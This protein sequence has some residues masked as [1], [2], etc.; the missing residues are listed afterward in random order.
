MTPPVAT[1]R[2]LATQAGG[3]FRLSGRGSAAL[4]ALLGLMLL[5]ATDQIVPATSDR[6]A[7]LRL[8]LAARA[9]GLVA[10]GLLTV[11]VLIGLVLSHPNN[12]ATWKLSKRIFP[13]HD[14]LWIFV[15]AFLVV[16]VLSLIGDP[17]SHVGIVGAFVP[18]MSEYRTVAVALGT[19]GLYALLITAVSARWTKLLPPG[20]W[21]RLH[22]LSIVVFLAAWTHGVLS[23]TD[24][25]TL[26]LAYVAAG[27]LVALAA[28][29]R[30][31][32]IRAAR[33]APAVT[34]MEV[35]RT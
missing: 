23:G 31:W 29:Y 18:G 28:A 9:T 19:I 3:A 24:T 27:V 17:K 26:R 15:T 6:Q 7:E 34:H 13:W 32:V 2:R 21:L 8:W 33:K 30:Y 1:H 5:V 20:V 35:S 12:K 14:H 10:F 16:H 22:R 4:F 25:P 11:Q